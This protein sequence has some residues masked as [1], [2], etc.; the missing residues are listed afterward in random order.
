MQKLFLASLIIIGFAVFSF[1]SRS[2][3]AGVQPNQSYYCQSGSA[4]MMID[5]NEESLQKIY[6]V[7]KPGDTI[8]LAQ[9]SVNVQRLCDF[10]KSVAL[11][12][13]VTVCV[14]APLRPTR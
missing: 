6:S 14:L 11:A 3:A 4:L 1:S 7:C 8:G 9:G 12:N 10:T 5:D 2:L 13:R